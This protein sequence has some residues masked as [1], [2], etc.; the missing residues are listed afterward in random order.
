METKFIPK[1]AKAHGFSD[2]SQ[3]E[4][5]NY[6]FCVQCARAGW[7][8]ENTSNN[9]PQTQQ[10]PLRVQP[11]L[12]VVGEKNKEN[13]TTIRNADGKVKENLLGKKSNY[14]EIPA[15]ESPSILK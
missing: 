2:R 13:C 1:L 8:P 7:L 15:S 9:T 10:S 3:P 12:F 14:T 5:G 6:A 4:M 11:G